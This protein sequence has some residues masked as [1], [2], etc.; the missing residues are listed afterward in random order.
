MERCRPERS[1]PLNSLARHAAGIWTAAALVLAL[2]PW[3]PAHAGGIQNI[4]RGARAMARGGASV[5]GSDDL[6]G[7]YLNP[8]TLIGTPGLRF[9][10]DLAVVDFRVGALRYPD[11][12]G[13]DP[14]CCSHANSNQPYL[15][16]GGGLG[17]GAPSGKWAVAFSVFGPYAG[18]AGYGA[19]TDA[20]YAIVDQENGLAYA[21][22]SGAWQPLPGLKLGLGLQLRE[23]WMHQQF[24]GS[25]Y[26][27]LFGAPE[28]RELDA[29]LDVRV[30]DWF[31]PGIVLGLSW[32]PT[33][34]LEIG[35][36]YQSPMDAEAE[37][38]LQVQIPS[39]YLFIDMEQH[40]ESVTVAT[41]IPDMA[42]A[43]LRYAAG[44]RWDLELAAV[45]ERWSRHE[46]IVAIPNEDIY[47]SGVPALGEFRMQ[48]MR[49]V[50]DYQDT[51][52]LRLGGAFAVLP[53]R[54]RLRAGTFVENGAA[55]D[56]SVTPGTYD[57]DKLGLTCG[58]GLQLGNWDLDLAY[59]HVF[60]RSR[61]V[62]ASRRRQVNPLYGEEDA[63]QG[64]T[65]VGNGE[66]AAALDVVALGLGWRFE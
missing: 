28:D 11:P 16:P 55:P 4:E 49:L 52:S 36:S 46:D 17:Y 27:G 13:G 35:L 29:L 2:A 50:E 38:T 39:H 6:N 8:A 14:E 42:R 24:M 26:T 51:L 15:N 61:R 56:S 59:G 62:T 3:A 65:I 18:V 66:Y 25:V 44:S 64:P 58:L 32:E 22:L 5:L 33:P 21:Q 53:G 57:A 34:G 9:N 23:F 41:G 12:R 54:L 31:R 1:L 63:A 48:T 45:W 20:R 19:D 37:G 60:L 30:D 10:A 7:A 47:F 43:A 40:G